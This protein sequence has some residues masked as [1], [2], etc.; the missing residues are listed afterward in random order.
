MIAMRKETMD[1][2]QHPEYEPK[3]V[4]MLDPRA[5]DA[6]RTAAEDALCA[7]LE[8]WGL[9]PVG[10]TW[11]APDGPLLAE[12]MA[13]TVDAAQLCVLLEETQQRVAHLHEALL[14]LA[15]QTETLTYALGKKENNPLCGTGI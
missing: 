15:R 8:P 4:S 6:V 9:V 13:V 11:E 14:M 5:L 1:E 7:R 2:P 3:S 12:K 10:I